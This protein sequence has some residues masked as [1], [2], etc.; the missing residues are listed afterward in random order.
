MTKLVSSLGLAITVATVTLLAGCDLYF[1]DHSG[2]GGGGGGGNPPGYACGNGSGSDSQCAAGCYCA[3][4]TCTEGGFCTTDADCRPGFHCDTVRSSSVPTPCSCNSDA[5]AI[6]QGFDWCDEATHTCNTGSD[7]AG[8]C[9]GTVTCTNAAPNCAEHQVPLIKDGYYTGSCR[10][11]SAC[12]GNAAC[13]SLQHED[14]CLGRATDCSASYNGINCHKPDGTAC[15]S[16]DTNCT[17]QSYVFAKCV[18]KGMARIDQF[19][20]VI[21]GQQTYSNF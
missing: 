14:D 2:S 7:P 11:I 19:G 20:N 5:D 21:D 4:G 13:G 16:G 1:K 10:D 9:T 3:N 18:V 6:K 17:C 12:E 8:A 15:H